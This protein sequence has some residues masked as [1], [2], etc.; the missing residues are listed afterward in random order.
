MKLAHNPEEKG[1]GHLGETIPCHTDAHSYSLLILRRAL[2][3]GRL[4]EGHCHTET[5]SDDHGIDN[6]QYQCSA[7]TGSADAKS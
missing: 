2:E 1:A 3:Y 4:A 6:K 5:E 7:N